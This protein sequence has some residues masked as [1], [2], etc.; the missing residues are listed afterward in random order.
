MDGSD[1]PVTT[2][3]VRDRPGPRRPVVLGRTHA[4]AAAFAAAL[5][6]A[7]LIAR[8]NTDTTTKLLSV[9]FMGVFTFVGFRFITRIR[10][11]LRP[12]N[13]PP[14]EKNPSDPPAPGGWANPTRAQTFLTKL[15]R[16]FTRR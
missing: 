11:A 2:D 7:L 6:D 16:P 9:I 3:P 1:S 10:Y 5:V 15:R 13:L 14:G 8:A 4:L 12:P